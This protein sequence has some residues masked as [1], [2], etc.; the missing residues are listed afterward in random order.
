MR[1]DDQQAFAQTGLPSGFVR[2]RWLLRHVKTL[3]AA[4]FVAILF[5]PRGSS[6]GPRPLAPSEAE[7]PTCRLGQICPD[8]GREGWA[9]RLEALLEERSP[10]LPEATRRKVARAVVDESRAAGIDPLL[11]A[12]IIDVESGFDVGARSGRGAHGLMQLRPETMAREAARHGMAAGD[13]QDPV[14]NVRLGLRYFGRL[15]ETF[16]REDRALMAYNAGPN[17]I[18]GLLQHG[19][20]PPRYRAYPARVYSEH[21]RLRRAFGLEPAVAIADASAPAP[22]R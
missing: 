19:R 8:P 20:I 13:P 22:V 4:A 6:D 18:G 7:L 15:V 9:A 11:A 5:V 2:R 14:V 16:S 21:R 3:S 10:D 12:A 17:R 1:L